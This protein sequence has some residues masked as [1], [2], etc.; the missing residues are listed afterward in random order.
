MANRS[1]GKLAGAA[2]EGLMKPL[3][4]LLKDGEELA[5]IAKKVIKDSKG[6]EIPPGV[7]RLPSGRLPANSRYAGKQFPMD[8][9]PPKLREKYPNGVHFTDDGFPDFSPYSTHSVKFDPPGFAGN[10][11]TDFTHA[12]RLAGI[13]E[14]PDTHT[15]H[16]H[17]DGHTM[18]LVPT[19][20]HDAVRHAGGVAIK[21]GS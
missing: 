3:A 9:L 1:L 17:Q 2:A 5:D 13:P 19:D 18:Q 12:N 6:R 10:H 7:K 14:A 16:H 21:K 20:L 8:K 11:G 15:W 4:K